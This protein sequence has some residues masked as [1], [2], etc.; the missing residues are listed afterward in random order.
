M[1]ALWRYR[2]LG[3]E[4]GPVSREALQELLESG[5]LSLSDEVAGAD[6]RWQPLSSLEGL[7]AT[8]R[9]PSPPE[10]DAHLAEMLEQVVSGP[11]EPHAT[12]AIDST[13]GWYARVF[14]EE[15]GPFDWEQLFEL[16]QQEELSVSDEVRHGR[17][18]VW[19]PAGEIVGLFPE[20]TTIGAGKPVDKED[21]ALREKRWYYDIGQGGS[22]KVSFATLQQMAADGRLKP[23]DRIRESGTTLWVR[24]AT[25]PGLFAEL[26]QSR[27][28][29]G[30]A[31]LAAEHAE[32]HQETPAE[33]ASRTRSRAQEGAGNEATE[34]AAPSSGTDAAPGAPPDD[35]SNFFDR[36][37]ARERKKWKREKLPPAPKPAIPN[38]SVPA[39]V[40]SSSEP[41]GTPAAVSS[42]AEA[43]ES[44]PAMTANAA[45]SLPSPPSSPGS[46]VVF[47]PA[48]RPKRSL[49]FPSLDLSGLL[50]RFQGGG[51]GGA[52]KLLAVLGVVA[53]IVAFQFIPM[54][55][56]GDPGVEDYP[57]VAALWQKALQL[58]K[59]G[60]EASEWTALKN[61]ALPLMDEMQ[62]RLAPVV[63][64]E[65]KDV[66][67]AQR[68]LWMVDK[69][70]GPSGA[71]GLLRKILNAGPSAA[72]TDINNAHA[73]MS[74]AGGLIPRS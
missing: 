19:E 31:E 60:G 69:E 46:P 42:P 44:E 49:R 23:R 70:S 37:E 10:L 11:T 13:H 39:A 51:A 22:K 7:T 20:S 30:Q 12:D 35:W 18:G 52:Y 9:D 14:G 67:V 5:S 57:R 3:E 32:E 54:S 21:S 50:S 48:P 62:A 6:G 33:E 29:A 26:E 74:E 59:A 24:A 36:V 68:V 25:Q 28:L 53:L 45:V 38:A 43:K 47:S 66:P 71:P 61:E 64:R 34:A 58:N 15:L 72:E 16:V 55:F 4:F 73:I 8:A 41:A 40:G 27:T 63:D 17:D 65:G 2:L 56:G 1:S